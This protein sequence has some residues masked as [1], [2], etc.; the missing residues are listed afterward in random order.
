MG[1]IEG[2]PHSL[3]ARATS[4]LFHPLEESHEAQLPLRGEDAAPPP[5][6][7]EGLWTC[8]KAKSHRRAPGLSA[9]SPL[10]SPEQAY[11][12][13]SPYSVLAAHLH[14]SS[15]LSRGPGR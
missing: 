3:Y 13:R 8:L 9:L 6:R 4:R 14:A 7:E 2:V 5:R 15:L 10:R 12:H 1:K 11:S